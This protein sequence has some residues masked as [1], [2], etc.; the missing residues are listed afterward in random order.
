MDEG[1][2]DQVYP[3]CLIVYVLVVFAVV[4]T[5]NF[6]ANRYNKSYD[7][8]SNKQFA[9]F[10]SNHQDREEPSAAGDHRL[11]GSVH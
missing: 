3:L 8:T 7:A 10:R 2:P 9:P 11:L 5:V 1:A 4:S 6:L